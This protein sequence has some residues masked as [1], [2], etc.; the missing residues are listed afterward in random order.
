LKKE[1]REKIKSLNN[2]SFVKSSDKSEF[3]KD[4]LLQREVLDT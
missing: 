2:S 3:V 1:N 4:P